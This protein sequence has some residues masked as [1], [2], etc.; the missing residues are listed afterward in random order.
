MKIKLGYACNTYTLNNTPSSVMTYTNYLKHK[1]LN[2]LDD[3]IISN[4]KALEEILK[5]NIKNDI[6]F[7][8]LTSKLIPL[9]IKDDVEFDYINRYKKYFDDLKTYTSKMRIDM[10]PDQ[11]T[12]INSVKEDVVKNSISNLE[13]HYKI[14]DAFGI[15][16]KVLILHIGSSVLGKKNSI[17]RFINNFNK[18]PS[19]LQK[20]IAI[21]NDDKVFNVLDCLYIAKKLKIPMVLDYHHYLCNNDG[22]DISELFEEIFNTWVNINPKMHF[23]SPKSKLK[24]EF[25]SHHDYINANDFIIFLNKI[26][27]LNKDIDIML[28]AKCKDE[29]LFRLIRELKYLTDYKIE[30]TTIYIP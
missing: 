17:S 22:E 11:F 18:M 1:D 29:S 15:K 26:K 28:E 9:A 19:H 13:Y 2:K 3:M 21:E 7:F 27:N 30:G 10:H 20:C 5:Y 23:S 6:F 14:L 16:N 24:K 8:R 25:R 4:F 12:V